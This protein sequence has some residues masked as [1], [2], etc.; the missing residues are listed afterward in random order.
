MAFRSVPRPS[1]PPGAKASTECPYFARY[2]RPN[3]SKG[4]QSP[5]RPSEENRPDPPRTGAIHTQIQ[6]SEPSSNATGFVLTLHMWNPSAS[7]PTSF[8][9][10]SERRC[11]NCWQPD[12]YNPL[13]GQTTAIDDAPRDAPEPDLQLQRTTARQM[14]STNDAMIDATLRCAEITTSKHDTSLR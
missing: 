1:S 12:H 6:E 2:L 5:S 8:H 7:R 13:T 4:I 14:P 3:S 9:D 10:A 11:R